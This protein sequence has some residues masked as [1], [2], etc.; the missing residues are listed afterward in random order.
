MLLDGG[1]LSSC[2]WQGRGWSFRGCFVRLVAT[3]GDAFRSVWVKGGVI[4]AR[5]S[6]AFPMTVAINGANPCKI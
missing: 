3:G 4:G 6:G 5:S 1:G 2:S